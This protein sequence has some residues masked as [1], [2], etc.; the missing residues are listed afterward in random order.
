[1]WQLFQQLIDKAKAQHDFGAL[2]IHTAA[3]Q[4]VERFLF[5][6]GNS[7]TVAALY[8]VSV[9]LQLGLGIH[10]RMMTGQ[11]VLIAEVGL[12][13]LGIFMDMDAAIKYRFAMVTI[14]PRKISLVVQWGTACSMQV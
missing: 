2:A 3:L 13:F 9:D 6:P 7:C 8:V 12:G 1:M 11:Q 14:M 5:K 4:I 10:F